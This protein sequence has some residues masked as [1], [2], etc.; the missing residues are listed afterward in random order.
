MASSLCASK[1]KCKSRKRRNISAIERNWCYNRASTK[2]VKNST[3]FWLR[4]EK[5]RTR[6]S[7]EIKQKHVTASCLND[8]PINEAVD[9]SVCKPF[10]EIVV[11]TA[12]VSKQAHIS[13]ESITASGIQ[14]KNNK[15]V[16]DSSDIKVVCREYN[17]STSRIILD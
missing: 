8:V 4:M 10:N 17:S 6:P 12:S 13:I 11:H 15:V 7:T 16:D 5:I 2:S 14:K 9:L 3:I 1:S